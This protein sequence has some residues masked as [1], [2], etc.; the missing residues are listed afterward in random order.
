MDQNWLFV[1]MMGQVMDQYIRA[2]IL[3]QHGQNKRA[4]DQGIGSL[5]L[6]RRMDPNWLRVIMGVIYIQA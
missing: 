4:L 5:L 2:V 1:G 6:P 3:E